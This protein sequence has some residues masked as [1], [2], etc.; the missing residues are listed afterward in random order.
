MKTCDVCRTAKLGPVPANY[1]VTVVR[2]DD[3]ISVE[4]DLCEEHAKPVLG[5]AW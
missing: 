1:H 4:M 5:V 3:N 2:L